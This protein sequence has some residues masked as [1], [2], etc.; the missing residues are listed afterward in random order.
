MEDIA[1]DHY[2]HLRDAIASVHNG[3]PTLLHQT[4]LMNRLVAKG[5]LALMRTCDD[6]FPELHLEALVSMGGIVHYARDEEKREGRI[7]FRRQKIQEIINA[8][9]DDPYAYE[10]TS[11][12]LDLSVNDV[13]ECVEK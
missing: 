10:H 2:I 8:L 4:V 12:E 1:A 13:L 5:E 7:F 9:Q 6:S 3:L 11:F